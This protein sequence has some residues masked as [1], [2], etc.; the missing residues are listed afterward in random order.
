MVKSPQTQ[1]PLLERRPIVL[2]NFLTIP[3]VFPFDIEKYP[4]LPSQN[5]T[6]AFAFCPALFHVV[7]NVENHTSSYILKLIVEIDVKNG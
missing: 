5:I 2:F 1:N 3:L 7:E 6:F 4:I